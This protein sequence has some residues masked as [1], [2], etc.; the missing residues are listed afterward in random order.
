MVARRSALALRS[1]AVSANRRSHEGLGHGGEGAQPRGVERGAE[2]RGEDVEYLVGLVKDDVVVS[3]QQHRSRRQVRGVEV[4]VDDDEVALG[5][6]VLGQFVEAVVTLGTLRTAEAFLGGH[7]EAPPGAR[8]DLEAAARRG[9]R[10]SV[11]SAQRRIRLIWSATPLGT[12]V[13]SSK[14]S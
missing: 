12:L 7:R 11:S 9:R 5:G 6:A 13:P 2:Q 4:G 3:G 10:S 14:L 8:V 1:L